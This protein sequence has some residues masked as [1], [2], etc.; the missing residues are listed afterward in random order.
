MFSNRVLRYTGVGLLAVAMMVA[1]F[2]KGNVINLTFNG[3]PWLLPQTPTYATDTPADANLVQHFF[4]NPKWFSSLAFLVL[5]MLL[6]A[7]LIYLI[8]E[9]RSYFRFTCLVYIILT[10]FSFLIIE[11]G[12]LTGFSRTGYAVA[13]NFKELLLSPFVVMLLIPVYM[14]HQRS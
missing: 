9:K 10:I 2:F 8:F 5:F 12:N 14:L 7:G 6:S 4:I 13:Q 11:A 1:G 3:Q